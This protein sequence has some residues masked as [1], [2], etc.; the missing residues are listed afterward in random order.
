M[1]NILS[2]IYGN[3]IAIK[4]SKNANVIEYY[5]GKKYDIADIAVYLNPSMK[6]AILW[7][8]K[9]HRISNGSKYLTLN[10]TWNELELSDGLQYEYKKFQ[11]EN[12]LKYEKVL[13]VSFEALH[14][15][16]Y[17][18]YSYLKFDTDDK[19]PEELKKKDNFLYEWHD[20]KARE[21]KSTS[22]W[23]RN[24][25]FRKIVLENYNYSCAICGCDIEQIL[26]AAHIVAVSNGGLDSV[27]NGIC[28]C[29]NH[30]KLYDEKFFEID[31][32]S[33]SVCNID[34]SVKDYLNEN[35][36]VTISNKEKA[37][38]EAN[39]GDIKM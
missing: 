34:N 35:C 39:N 38:E 37:Q 30:H 5:T 20:E 12:C 24:Q 7:D 9:H 28:L 4:V 19:I 15:I 32:V 29:R 13:I 1:K 22:T 2:Q 21:R 27:D 18:L 23:K 25:K 31:F 11:T 6:I 36:K 14:S 3:K 8:L 26:E 16:K 17:D 10:S 33:H